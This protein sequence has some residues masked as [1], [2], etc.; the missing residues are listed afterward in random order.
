M[1]DMGTF[2]LGAAL[3]MFVL[4]CDLSLLFVIFGFVYIAEAGSSFIQILSIRFRNKRVFKIAPLHHLFEAI[5]WSETKVVFR[6]WVIHAILS[7]FALGV[8]F[9]S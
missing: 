6:F 5:G 4:M 2:T 1:G 7:L 3:A 8:Y 9:I